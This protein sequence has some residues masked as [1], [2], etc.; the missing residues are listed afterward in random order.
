MLSYS[1]LFYHYTK[2]C[3]EEKTIVTLVVLCFYTRN[4]KS[5]KRPLK[6]VIPLWDFHSSIEFFEMTLS[7]TRIPHSREY[8]TQM[9]F[10]SRNCRRYLKLYGN[11]FLQGGK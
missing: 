1:R 5:P 8:A 3:A 2:R 4:F 11:E 9:K 10:I 7:S 6:I